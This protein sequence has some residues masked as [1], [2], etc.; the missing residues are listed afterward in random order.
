MI[1]TPDLSHLKRADYE[2][3]Y[4]PAGKRAIVYYGDGKRL[5]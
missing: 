1:P 3:I 2:H 4:E 5:L